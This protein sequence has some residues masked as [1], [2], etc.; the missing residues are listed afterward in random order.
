[1][2]KEATGRGPDG[3]AL[4]GMLAVARFHREHERFHSMNGLEQAAEIRRDSNALKVLAQRWLEA[5]ESGRS[6]LDYDD[7]RFQA[8]GCDDLNDKAAVATTGILFME[9]ESEPP[10]IGQM[11]TKLSGMAAGFD[12][13]AGWL[14]Q[15]MEAG[16]ERESAL[17]TPELASAAQP[18]F[19]ALARTTLTGLG[20]GVV[21]RLLEAAVTALSAQV[22]VPAAVRKDLVGSAQLLLAASW[23]LDEASSVLAEQ[24]ADIARSDPS[25]TAYIEDLQAREP[26]GP[27]PGATPPEP[28]VVTAGPT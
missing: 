2:A 17:L 8:A 28:F 3:A 25:W 21:S 26:T 11:K 14:A 18:R 19:A 10:E 9:G 23:L 4:E 1:M 20:L 6:T 12:R 5:A 15:K 13:T 24:A 22:L 7:P 27:P 16:W